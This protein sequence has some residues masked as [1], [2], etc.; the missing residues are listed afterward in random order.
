VSFHSRL[1]YGG[2]AGR[3]TCVAAVEDG[4]T[5]ASG[6]AAGSIHVWR[7]QT[8]ARL[9]GG[10]PDRYTGEQKL[11]VRKCDLGG[12]AQVCR[13]FPCGKCDLGG[14]LTSACQAGGLEVQW[15]EGDVFPD[16]QCW[17]RSTLLTC[18]CTALPDVP[19]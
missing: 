17:P 13:K 7:V 14:A 3:I 16:L 5:I 11:S 12:G 18:G 15:V 6:S 4:A 8:T 10:P 1:T 2:Q 19:P 9:P